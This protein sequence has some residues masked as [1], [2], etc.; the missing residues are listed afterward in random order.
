[1]ICQIRLANFSRIDEAVRDDIMF[2]VAVLVG[3]FQLSVMNLIGIAA[4]MLSV[5]GFA[6]AYKLLRHR[7]FPIRVRFLCV[8]ALLAAPSI[9]FAVY[10]FHVLPEYEWFYTLRSWPGSEFLA[11]FLGCAGGIAASLLPRMFLILPLFAVLVTAVIPHVK[12]MLVPLSDAEF[13]DKW[14]GNACLQSTASTCGPASVATILRHFGINTTEQ[15]IAHSAFSYEG[16]TEAWYLARY[17]RSCG[18]SPRFIF[19]ATF[20]PEA[21]QPALVGVRIGRAGHFI[22]VLDV[23]GDLV[24]VADPLSGETQLTLTEFRHHYEF[25]CFHMVVL[26]I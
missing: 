10:Y 3:H 7:P 1:M 5:V 18:L 8:F 23:R 22:A 13:H 15:A 9:L 4:V 20:S 24:T 25:T 19:R 11:V 17:V 26:H 21:G 6:V 14:Q 16:G 12:P 2:P